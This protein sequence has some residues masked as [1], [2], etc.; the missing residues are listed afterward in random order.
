MA[1]NLIRRVLIHNV[2]KDQQQIITLLV[3][4]F[5]QFFPFLLEEQSSFHLRKRSKKI[6][7]VKESPRQEDGI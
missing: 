7:Q 3:H 4:S 1:L 2:F 5:D 6:E